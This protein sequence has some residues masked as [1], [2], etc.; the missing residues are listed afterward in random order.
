LKQSIRLYIAKNH[1]EREVKVRLKTMK[2]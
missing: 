2:K 1:H